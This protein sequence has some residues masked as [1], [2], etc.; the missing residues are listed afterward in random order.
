MLLMPRGW[1][2]RVHSC[3]LQTAKKAAR[4]QIKAKFEER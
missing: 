1:L 3:A 4:K 2:T